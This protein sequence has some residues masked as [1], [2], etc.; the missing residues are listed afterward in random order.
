MEN[1]GLNNN[2]I[3]QLLLQYALK[4]YMSSKGSQ[5]NRKPFQQASTIADGEG[6][7][8]VPGAGFVSSNPAAALGVFGSM[9]GMAVPG[10]GF[11]GSIMG[12]NK[13]FLS[14]LAD[15]FNATQVDPAAEQAAIA[16]EAQHSLS[17]NPNSEAQ[18]ESESGYGF[19]EGFG[20]GDSADGD[21]EGG[22]GE[23]M[24]GPGE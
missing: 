14:N 12:N 5:S 16:A 21:S 8:V 9:L 24:S 6:T 4:Q 23:G 18:A 17:L 13:G 2:L 20:L 11:L 22:F 10:M 7:G 1:I 3:R 15:M 19:S